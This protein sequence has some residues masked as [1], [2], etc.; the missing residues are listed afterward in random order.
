MIT[1]VIAAAALLA[2]NAQQ[3]DL[4]CTG[5]VESGS[6]LVPATTEPWEGRLRIDLARGVWCEG[7]CRSPEPF[8][9]VNAGEFVLFDNMTA[10]G[11]GRRESVNRTTGA[12]RSATI[13]KT[14]GSTIAI[15]YRAQ[16][17]KAE[18]TPI[19]S[20]QF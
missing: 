10:K 14:S 3:F 16:C 13:M 19:P 2:A 4:V 12:Y 6:T 8:V 15:S 11:E 5:T 20:Q 7:V 9:S 17:T 18:Y 1:T